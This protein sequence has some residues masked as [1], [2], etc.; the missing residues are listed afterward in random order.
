MQYRNTLDLI[1]KTFIGETPKNTIYMILLYCKDFQ[2]LQQ[3]K[4]REEDKNAYKWQFETKYAKNPK[5]AHQGKLSE[6]INKWM[7]GKQLC[8]S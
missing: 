5:H 2:M 7:L 6:C 1:L 8:F 4:M 3:I